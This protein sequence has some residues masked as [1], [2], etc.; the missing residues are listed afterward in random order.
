MICRV[1]AVS[2]K[3][4]A[5]YCV[6]INKLILRFTWKGKGPRIA[7]SILEKNKVRELTQLDLNT[8]HQNN[9]VSAKEQRPIEQNR[10]QK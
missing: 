6:D 2:I 5:S 1:N 9:L 10:A 8:Y 7:N 4:P 3:I